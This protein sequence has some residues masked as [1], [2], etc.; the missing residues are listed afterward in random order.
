M[1]YCMREYYNLIGQNV[2]S[3]VPLTFIINNGLSDP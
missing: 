1:F 2:F 3:V